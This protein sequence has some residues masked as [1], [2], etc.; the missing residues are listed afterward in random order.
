MTRAHSPSAPPHPAAGSG[1]RQQRRWLLAA[2]GLFL[3]SIAA[4]L[5]WG[6][7]VLWGVVPNQSVAISAVDQTFARQFKA[8]LVAGPQVDLASETS[9]PWQIVC[10]IEPFE[11][12]AASLREALHAGGLPEEKVELPGGPVA[13]P[14][15]NWLFTFIDGHRVVRTIAFHH[16][17]IEP[18]HGPYC[19][20]RERARFAGFGR[21]GGAFT[22]DLAP[23][24]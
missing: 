9:F 21:T 24:S 22:I 8:H 5:H 10:V 7:N 19:V 12:D 15:P 4:M 1:R 13:I 20:P 2:A 11:L 17:E 6:L 23:W 18:R 16:R 14:Q 3:A